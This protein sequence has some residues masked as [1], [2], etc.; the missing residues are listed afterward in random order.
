MGNWNWLWAIFLVVALIGVF[1]LSYVANHR[2]PKPKGC[3]NLK[4]ECGSCP[5]AHCG[6]RD[7]EEDKSK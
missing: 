7:K 6:L 4:P 1:I 3:E 5:V 2:T